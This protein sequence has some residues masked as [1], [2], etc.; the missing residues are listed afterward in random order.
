MI[1]ANFLPF[2]FR[3][4]LENENDSLCALEAMAIVKRLGLS[5]GKDQDIVINMCTEIA[6]FKQKIKR[7]CI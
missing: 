7:L 3:V 1:V 4:S 6:T 5:L 2:R